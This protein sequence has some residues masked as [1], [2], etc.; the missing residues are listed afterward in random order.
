ML[1]TNTFAHTFEG[2][3]H[4]CDF[5]PEGLAS[6]KETVNGR[7]IW[8]VRI[9]LDP[10]PSLH[11][12]Y[13]ALAQLYI[14]SLRTASSQLMSAEELPCT[15]AYSSSLT[16]NLLSSTDHS[17]HIISCEALW[18]SAAPWAVKYNEQSRQERYGWAKGSNSAQCPR[19][20]PK[21][22]SRLVWIELFALI[23][24][25]AKSILPSKTKNEEARWIF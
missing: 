25:L 1:H 18:D 2:S 4:H 6:Q 20:M 22:C 24:V 8:K 17:C 3:R 7:Q 16:C 10:L 15:S 23:F 12:Q 21:L 5:A 14:T 19:T 11:T 9:T 13:V